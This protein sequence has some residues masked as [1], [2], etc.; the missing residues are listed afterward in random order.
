M[1][2]RT[3]AIS[4]YRAKAMRTLIKQQQLKLPIKSFC[5]VMYT[6]TDNF[7]KTA[8]FTE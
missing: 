8:V 1:N 6:F 5:I 3:H 4:V 7:L 2:I